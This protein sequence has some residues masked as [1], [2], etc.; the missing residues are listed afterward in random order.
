MGGFTKMKIKDVEWTGVNECMIDA[1]FE[2]SETKK[3]I[4][5]RGLLEVVE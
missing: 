2:D 1:E 5:L 4:K 3:I